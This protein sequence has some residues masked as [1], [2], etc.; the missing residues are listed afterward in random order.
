MY[1]RRSEWL[2][3]A[4]LL[5]LLPALWRSLPR[6]ALM[7]G[8]LDSVGFTQKAEYS[9]VW[10]RDVNIQLSAAH[11]DS[12]AQ[13]ASSQCNCLSPYFSM[14][15]SR[16]PIGFDLRRDVVFY[17]RNNCDSCSLEHWCMDCA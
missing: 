9:E 1:Q 16:F 8:G 14:P 4:T 5:G 11:V 10:Q 12:R 7:K 17:H 6:V 13:L 2:P 3:M 15:K